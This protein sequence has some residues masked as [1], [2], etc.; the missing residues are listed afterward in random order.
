MLGLCRMGRGSKR[1]MVIS[2]IKMP[3]R[4][5]RQQ[6]KGIK[7]F[8]TGARQNCSLNVAEFENDPALQIDRNHST[9]MFRFHHPITKTSEERN[10]GTK[11][12]GDGERKA[13]VLFL[14][15]T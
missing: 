12:H 11:H 14:G 15:A 2:E 6:R 1:N 9:G 4:T 13:V 8:C 3:R 10:V 7:H 5:A